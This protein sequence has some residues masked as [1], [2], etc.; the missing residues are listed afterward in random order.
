MEKYNLYIDFD[1]VILDTITPLYKE[2]EEKKIKKEN[3]T[4]F[5][6]KYPWD[7]II[8]DKYII[9][10]SIECIFKLIKT[11]KYNLAILT[12]VNSLNEA[13]LKI[14]YLRKYFKDITIIPCP[15]EIS[16]T[17]M[18]HTKDAI[19]VDDYAGNLREWEKEGGIPV[20]FNIKRNGKGFKVI[21]KLDELIDMFD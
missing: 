14:K 7:T 2:I 6:E 10:D 21:S 20:R 12:H 3:L 1:G 8:K 11:K 17:K 4:K 19:L 5:Y 13:V 9:N 15:K 16:K 18:I